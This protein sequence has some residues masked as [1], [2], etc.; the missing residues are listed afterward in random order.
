MVQNIPAAK[1]AAVRDPAPVCVCKPAEL[2][3]LTPKM[4]KEELAF[5]PFPR[6][7]PE[8]QLTA[9]QAAPHFRSLELGALN[10]GKR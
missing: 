2:R 8:E 6:E 1:P 7:D 3:Q 5:C 10:G 4:D 9:F